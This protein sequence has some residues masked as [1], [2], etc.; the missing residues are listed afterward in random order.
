[1]HYRFFIETFSIVTTDTVSEFQI[2]SEYLNEKFYREIESQT[3]REN[4]LL[5]KS[6]SKKESSKNAS[7]EVYKIFSA[8]LEQVKPRLNDLDCTNN[9]IVALTTRVLSVYTL[10][11]HQRNASFNSQRSEF[12]SSLETLQDRLFSKEDSP[13]TLGEMIPLI[14]YFKSDSKKSI[15]T[16]FYTD[17]CLY[18][19]NFILD[20]GLEKKQDFNEINKFL[21]TLNGN[22]MYDMRVVPA[23]SNFAQRNQEAII[24]YKTDEI[25]REYLMKTQEQINKQNEVINK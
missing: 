16:S 17:L 22:K 20:N 10:L 11:I 18:V 23:L 25:I 5:I 19:R 6:L 3:L 1:M 13:L 7:N 24:H 12:T 9:D 4:S 8:L 2:F 14:D 15:Y 21:A